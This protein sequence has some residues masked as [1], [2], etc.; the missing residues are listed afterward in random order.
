MPLN[1]LI[2]VLVMCYDPY[3]FL[4]GVLAFPKCARQV[5]ARRHL[6]GSISLDISLF[7]HS[8]VL[9]NNTLGHSGHVL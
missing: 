2:L 3:A 8:A 4:A 6:S 5:P 9:C 7:L 1:E